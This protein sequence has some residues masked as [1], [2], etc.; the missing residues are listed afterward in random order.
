[1]NRDDLDVIFSAATLGGLLALP[2]I[3]WWFRMM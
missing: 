2:E 3:G 1:M